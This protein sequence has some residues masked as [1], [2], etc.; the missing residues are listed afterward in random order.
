MV[1]PDTAWKRRFRRRILSWFRR[2]ARDL[3]WRKTRDPYHIWISEI[4]LQQTQVVTVVDYFRRFLQAFPTIAG[5]ARANEERVLR[6]WEGLGYYRR[7]R[8]LHKAASIIVDE[9]DGV[10]PRDMETI[11]SL[12]GIG[13]YTAG[14]IA[15]IAWDARQPILEANTTR[16]FSRLLAYRDDPTRSLGQKLLWGMAESLLPRKNAGAFNQALME[17]G[18]EICMP[19]RPLCDQC[20]IG[21]L[22]PTNAMGLQESIPASKKKTAYEDVTE[23]AVVVRRRDKVL[24]RRCG[25]GERWS[26]LW[27]FPRFRIVASRG[28]ALHQELE[29]KVAELTGLD[30]ETDR[31][32]ATIRHGVTRFRITLLCHEARCVRGRLRGENMRWVKPEQLK[33]YPLSVTGRKISELL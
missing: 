8:Q 23:A 7:A 29:A 22:C 2:H 20:P 18:S 32:L 25:D 9:H 16:V 3:P 5:L 12:P 31:K 11:R 19:R 1:F 17:L 26:G 30:V 24:L 14:A 13:R 15:S 27:D 4:M 6:L 28:E 33:D 21:D 10:F